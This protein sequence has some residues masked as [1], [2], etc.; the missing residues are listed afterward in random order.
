MSKESAH[1]DPLMS[2]EPNRRAP[3]PGAAGGREPVVAVS[4]SVCEREVPV[5][6][7]AIPEAT[8]YVVYLCGLDCYQR[9][10]SGAK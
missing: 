6:E 8:D 5:S 7:A 1:Q 9:W 3:P 2:A 10:R 4:C